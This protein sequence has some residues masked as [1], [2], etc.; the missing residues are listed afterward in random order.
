MFNNKTVLAVNLECTEAP[1]SLHS[2]KDLHHDITFHHDVTL[3]WD[4]S[5]I[6][7]FVHPS[8]LHLTLLY[9]DSDSDGFD[10]KCLDILPDRSAGSPPHRWLD[11]IESMSPNGERFLSLI[12]QTVPGSPEIICINSVAG[13]DTHQVPCSP[14]SPMSSSKQLLI[15]KDHC[16][17]PDVDN[18]ATESESS[19]S[20]D[21]DHIVFSSNHRTLCASEC[22]AEQ[23]YCVTPAVSVVETPS[24]EESEHAVF[25]GTCSQNSTVSINA[26]EPARSVNSCSLTSDHVVPNIEE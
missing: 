12:A 2:S 8:D 17:V 4:D 21:T 7:G 15:G 10:D 13:C 23:S 1:S 25:G 11:Y 16:T 9:D 19:D 24:T 14:A 3:Q 18:I 6:F 20:Y 5:P 26:W 22:E